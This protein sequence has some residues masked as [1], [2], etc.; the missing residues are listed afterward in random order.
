ME[1]LKVEK[2]IIG[3]QF[4]S[5][6]NL[7]KFQKMVS[8]LKINV[9]IVET[10]DRLNI[11]KNLYF[12]FLWPDS[13][14]VISENSINNNAIVCKFYYKNF[15]VLFTGDIEEEAEKVLVSKYRGTDILKSTV[16]KVA[17]HGSKSSSIREFLD[18]VKPKIALIGVGENNKF[19]HPNSGVIERLD[20]LRS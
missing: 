10:E 18:L 19:G 11:E 20:G 5:C 15:S 14:N 17:H 9:I 4:E 6:E 16:L 13:S 2:I 12:D 3:K 1:K 7:E 8:D